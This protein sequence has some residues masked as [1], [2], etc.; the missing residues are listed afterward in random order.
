MNTSKHYAVELRCDIDIVR[1][2]SVTFSL[3]HEDALK[4]IQLSGLVNTNNLYKVEAFDNTV[5][6][7][8]YFRTSGETLS[9]S[10]REFWFGGHEKY[11]GTSFETERL[12]IADLAKHFGLDI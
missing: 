7:G 9:V 11:S 10:A 2:S 3:G 4:I 6:Y 12:P 5:E 8:D 1:P